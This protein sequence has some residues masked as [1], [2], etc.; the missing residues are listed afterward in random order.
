MKRN[1]RFWACAVLF[2]CAVPALAAVDG[3]VR[4]GCGPLATLAGAYTSGAG[5]EC[6]DTGTFTDPRDG[7]VYRWV[8]IGS[9]VWMAENL[10]FK[11]KNGSW[12]WDNDEAE[13][14]K[15][16]RFYDW[17]T[18]QRAAPPGWHLASEKEWQELELFLGLTPEQIAQTGIE[19]GGDSNTIASRLKLPGSWPTEYEGKQI[20]ISNDT[21]F[22]AVETG[23]FARGQ[24]THAGYASWWTSTDEGDKAW[25]RMIGF[26]DNK[27]HRALN[28]KAFA[29]S[30]RCVKDAP[31]KK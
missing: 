8:R 10:R 27:S 18:A 25:V 14:K 1:V 4:G 15:R 11:P 26:S 13:C 19:R 6:L 16:G 12:C 20:E 28:K 31:Q 30:G 24:F 23:F 2:C 5:N 22:S 7:E 3:A 9:Q 29:F 17:D 21:G